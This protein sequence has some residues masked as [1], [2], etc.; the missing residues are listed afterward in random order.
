MICT[1]TPDRVLRL[2]GKATRPTSRRCQ[3][4]GRTRRASCSTFFSTRKAAANPELRPT[5]VG[6]LAL[7]EDEKLARVD[8]PTDIIG[9]IH[10]RAPGGKMEKILALID[11]EKAG[12]NKIIAI[13]RHRRQD[14]DHDSSLAS[15]GSR[16][17][18]DR[19]DP[20]RGELGF[21]T[22]RRTNWKVD[23][24][25]PDLVISSSRCRTGRFET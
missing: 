11:P 13:R 3:G 15:L 12:F 16:P 1:G 25:R 21:F 10:R 14:H 5:A 6:I 19:Q 23:R 8:A 17:R 22:L 18:G 24:R 2:I 7:I 20:E 9:L 4:P